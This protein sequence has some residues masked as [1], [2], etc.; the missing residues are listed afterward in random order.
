[1]RRLLLGI[2]ISLLFSACDDGDII[3]TSFDFEDS[4]LKFCSGPNKNV[5]YA[6]NNNDVYESISLEFSNNN[7]LDVDE[8]G[9]IIPP[10]ED[11]VSFPLSGSNRVVYRIYDSEV[12]NDYFC[13][14]VP[15]SSPDVIEE[16]VSGTGGT[17]I[18][19]TDFID[20][21]ATSDPDRD[22]LENREE[23]WNSLGE[24]L[25]DTD[26]DGIPDYLDK[27]DDGD[28]V[29]TSNE[30]ANSANDP[31]NENGYRDTDEDGIPNYLDNDDDNDGVLTRFEVEEGDE[32]NPAAFQTAQGISN[33]LNQEQTAEFQH[34]VYI[35]HD[36]TRNYGLQ[37][38]INNLKFEKQDGSGESI[39]FE[40]YNLGNLSSNSVD[41]PQCPGQDPDCSDTEEEEETT[42]TEG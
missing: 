1:M 11:Q 28:N 38:L 31:V 25:Q 23:G 2:F 40:T 14:V 15:P 34:E 19:N 20:E 7:Q 6:I 42:E 18:I 35:S 3:V 26:E 10:D 8:D 16:W 12:P 9:N 27:D 17:V 41:F 36:I 21:T 24:D 4:S 32:D 22:G 29:P 39:Q 37:I 33:Y 5:I 13:N 30:L